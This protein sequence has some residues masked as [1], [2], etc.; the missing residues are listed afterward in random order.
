MRFTK[1]QGCG[2]DYIYVNCFEEQ[3]EH[4][5]ETAKRLSRRHFG[6]GGDGLVLICPSLKADFRM[7][8][9]NADGSLGAM[10]GNGIRCLGKYVYEKGLTDKTDLLV[11]TNAGIRRLKLTLSQGKVKAVGV[12]MGIPKLLAEEIPVAAVSGVPISP[13]E[14]VVGLPLKVLEHTYEVT[15]V[16]MGN[17]H[18]VVFL[19]P[20]ESQVSELNL[21]VLGP[22]FER[23]PMFPDRVNVEFAEVV[24]PGQIRMRVWER[25][26]GET[27]ACGTGA[28]AAAVAGS[29]TGRTADNVAVET[30]GGCL[31]IQFD[32]KTRRVWMEGPAVTVFEGEV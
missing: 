14:K 21:P 28:C 30:I 3:V 5:S 13:R 19:K 18:A 1:M 24:D 6:I 20:G 26:S 10:C 32:A 27:F 11:E 15:C 2:N 7:T 8:M 31:Q 4:A 9:Y 25:G 22:A 23:H 29:L 17:P 12:D 16:S